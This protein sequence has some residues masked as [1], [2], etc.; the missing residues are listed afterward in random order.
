LYPVETSNI[1]KKAGNFNH[2][3]IRINP[4]CVGGGGDV[5]ATAHGGDVTVSLSK[6]P[7]KTFISSN[8]RCP[9]LE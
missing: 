9:Y 2:R 8:L 4:G 6:K 1:A 7:I 5:L 3:S